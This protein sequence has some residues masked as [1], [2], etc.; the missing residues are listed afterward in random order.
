MQDNLDP[1]LRRQLELRIQKAMAEQMDDVIGKIKDIAKKFSIENKDKK[2]PFRNVLSVA[3]SHDSSIEV[4]KLFI[5]SQIGKSSASPIWSTKIGEELFASALVKDI[6]RLEKDTKDIVQNVRI[7]IPKNN[8]L[9]NYVDNPDKQKEL[10]KQVHF[11]L[12]QRYLGY[13]AREHTALVGEAKLNSNS[14]KQ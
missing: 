2:S 12:A 14:Q 3:T 10:T 8:P 9:N 5:K 1:F 6:E 4:I 11:K 13:L 7:S